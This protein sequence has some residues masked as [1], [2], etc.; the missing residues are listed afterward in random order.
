MLCFCP[1]FFLQDV[2]IFLVL[3]IFTWRPLALP[4]TSKVSVFFFAAH[5]FSPNQHH[6]HSLEADAPQLVSV[7]PSLLEIF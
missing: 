5:M 2:T 7:L 6:Q 4:A 3:S 1:A